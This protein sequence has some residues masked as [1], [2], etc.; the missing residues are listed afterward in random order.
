MSEQS[1]I[2][3][4]TGSIEETRVCGK[5]HHGPWKLYRN[6]RSST[7][8]K[9]ACVT[10][11][12]EWQQAYEERRRNNTTPP[13]RQSYPCETDMLAEEYLA[14]RRDGYTLTRIATFWRMDPHTL[15]RALA[16]V[17]VDSQHYAMTQ[18]EADIMR[19]LASA[20]S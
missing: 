16:R 4:S 14:L 12:K 18:T 10:C 20:D 11:R 1:V 15:Q 6:S 3:T 19:S 7:G 2:D 13:Q 9:E 8:Y 5:G 17:G